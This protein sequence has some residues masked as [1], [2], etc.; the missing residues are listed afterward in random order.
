M[1]K[2]RVFETNVSRFISETI[3]YL[4]IG[5]VEIK[6]ELVCDLWNGTSSNKQLYSPI[7]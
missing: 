3:Q 7:I 6:K 2:L 1:K 4:A 5:T